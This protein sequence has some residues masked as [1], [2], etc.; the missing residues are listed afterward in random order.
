MNQI[1]LS[2]IGI[3]ITFSCFFLINHLF[4]GEWANRIA[5]FFGLRFAKGATKKIAAKTTQEVAKGAALEVGGQLFDKVKG[6]NIPDLDVKEGFTIN[7]TPQCYSRG[8]SNNY[9]FGLSI[10]DQCIAQPLGSPIHIRLDTNGNADTFSY[11]PPSA[12]GIYG[13]TQTACPKSKKY[14]CMGMV[15]CWDCCNYH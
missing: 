11:K 7:T 15:S 5:K 1:V 13:C 10:S 9:P 3:I 14:D 8:C 12:H 2:I 6:D 4:E